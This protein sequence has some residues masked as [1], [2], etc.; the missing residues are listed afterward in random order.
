M[1]HY[2]KQIGDLRNSSNEV[3][4]TAVRG[5]I[6]RDDLIML[7]RTAKGDLKFP[8]G[9]LEENETFEEALIREIREETG[10]VN[11][12]VKTDNPFATYI[13]RKIDKYDTQAIFESRSYYSFVNVIGEERIDVKLDD[14]E[15]VL[16]FQAEWIPIKDAI[17][18]NTYA[19]FSEEEPNDWVERE[20][21]IL[22]A[23]LEWKKSH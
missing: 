22:Q 19:L 6:L 23:L 10:Y 11:V 12:K 18:Q 15:E 14:Y 16:Q 8:G 5:I 2:V 9:G 1:I 20:I 13:E 21:T 3:V 7:I 4:R 17:I